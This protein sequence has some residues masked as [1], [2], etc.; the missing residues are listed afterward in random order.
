MSWVL[1][2]GVTFALGILVC[3]MEM[4]IKRAPCSTHLTRSALPHRTRPPQRALCV[5]RPKSRLLPPPRF[6]PRPW[7]HGQNHGCRELSVPVTAS[8]LRKA[9]GKGHVGVPCR[10]VSATCTACR[11]ARPPTS[12]H[13]LTWFRK[14][15]LSSQAARTGVRSWCLGTQ[16]S[17]ARL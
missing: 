3:K 13:S 4:A 11:V 17:S 14:F 15:R 1:A 5:P 12:V 16:G 6:M 10:I 8:V 9:E 7:N 2:P